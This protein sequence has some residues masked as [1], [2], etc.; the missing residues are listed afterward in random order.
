MKCFF[1]HLNPIAFSFASLILFQGCIV[2][3]KSKPISVEEASG[4]ENTKMKIATK[5][6]NN[7]KLKWIE[8]KNGNVVSIK[9]TERV[10][11]S[12]S[13]IKQ[14]K[15]VD[16]EPTHISLD[17]ACNHNGIAEVIAVNIE[18]Y[19]NSEKLIKIK[20][21]GDRII[22]NK[23]TKKD[24]ATVVI[25]IS[26]IR[27]IKVQNKATSAVANTVMG[28][29]ITSVTL[30]TILVIALACGYGDSSIW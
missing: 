19:I 21:D 20:R 4:Y 25:P 12:I 5:G 6:G 29:G 11:V 23:I 27:E 17:S 10:S 15:T 26:Y 24:T 8:E 14:I 30:F 22:G 1:K 18:G 7:Y 13:D 3:Y 9:N 16:H 28:V 2:V